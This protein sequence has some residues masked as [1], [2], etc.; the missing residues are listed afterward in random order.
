MASP[1][2][3]ANGVNGANGT[4]GG[5]VGRPLRAERLNRP[6]F[7]AEPPAPRLGSDDVPPDLRGIRFGNPD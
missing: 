3:T 5:R 1:P 7:R 2:A 4:A 6:R